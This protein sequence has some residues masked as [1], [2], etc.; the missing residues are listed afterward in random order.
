MS[1]Q[2]A[3]SV[4][5]GFTDDGLPIGVQLVGQRFDDLGT[6]RLARVIEQL[7]PPQLPWPHL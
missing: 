3:A 7:R 2:P 6:M 1:E 4:N 5:W